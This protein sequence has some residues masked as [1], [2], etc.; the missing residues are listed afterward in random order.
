[1]PV[2]DYYRGLDK[3]YEV[4]WLISSLGFYPPYLHLYRQL[5]PISPSLIVSL[6][7]ATETDNHFISSLGIP[8]DSD[9]GVWHQRGGLR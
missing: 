4:R 1:M 2:V 8:F 5:F 7:V 3:V 6:L 9:P